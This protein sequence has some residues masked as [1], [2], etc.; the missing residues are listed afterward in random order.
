MGTWDRLD[1]E[2]PFNRSDRGSMRHATVLLTVGLVGCMTHL[3]PEAEAVR[4]TTDATAVHG[5]TR[6]GEV[7]GDDHMHGG[8]LA[9]KAT[10]NAE[11]KLR[12]ATVQLGG[13]TVLL[14][15][16]AGGYSGASQRGEAFK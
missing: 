3:T 8:L 16:S 5:C 6:L 11:R 12:Q 1:S 4:I 10:E 14:L 15:S 13:N 2:S 7:K 9:G